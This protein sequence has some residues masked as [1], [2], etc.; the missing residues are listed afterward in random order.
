MT[1]LKANSAEA[2]F[3]KEPTLQLVKGS[4][5][6][7]S[8]EVETDS[9]F[10]SEIVGLTHPKEVTPPFS[11]IGTSEK[12]PEH[13]QAIADVETFRSGGMSATELRKK[14]ITTYKN[15]DDMKQ[16]C[17]G[18]PTSGKPAVELHLSLVKFAGFLEIAG[19][20]PHQ[21]WSLDRIDPTGPYS[22]KNLR[23][24]SKKTQ[25]RNRTN[26]VMLTSS[27]VTRPLVEWAEI[28]GQN[29]VTLRRRR[30]DGWN[31]EEI[32]KGHRLGPVRASGQPL[33]GS[34]NLFDHT[35]WPDQ[36]R[37]E[38]ERLFQIKRN[39]GEHRLTFLLEYSK[40]CI[41]LILQRAEFMAW[42]EEYIPTEAERQESD[43]LAER[44]AYW[45]NLYRDATEKFRPQYVS[46]LYRQR[47]LP[48]W[49]ENGLR[50]YAE[51]NR[52]S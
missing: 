11:E 12:S 23:W 42:P 35:P 25:S 48:T 5:K 31:D 28:I 13:V 16:R 9:L 44:Y 30:R 3:Q 19:P 10:I 41:E 45:S 27:G 33:N 43:S 47:C 34:R 17:K 7:C 26:T 15:W 38:L 39:N 2:G 52:E 40:K 46:Y 49:V 37:D 29:P 21:T 32:V 20:R 24:A 51:Q 14:Y 36:Y 50:K 22:P 6:N 4:G 1:A 18:D 8:G